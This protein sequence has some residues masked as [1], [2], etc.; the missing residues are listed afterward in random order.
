MTGEINIAKITEEVKAVA[1]E[2]G[3]YIQTQRKT[4]SEES[5]ERKSSHDYVSYVDK[6]S[7]KMITER[8]H[9]ILP[10]AGFVTEEHVVAQDASGHEFCWIVDPLDGTTNFIKDVPLYCVCIALRQNDEIIVGVV[11]ELTRNELFWAYKGGGAWVNKQRIHVSDNVLDNS[12]VAIGYPYNA[13]EYTQYVQRLT[14]KLYGNV[15]SIR[16]LGSAEGELCYVAAG[17]FD[18][19]VESFLKPWDVAAG[20]VIVKEAGGRISDY[21]DGDN[22]WPSGREVLAT[23]GA[24]HSLMID[25][26]QTIK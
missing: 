6:Q 7:E 4:F 21:S 20:A 2:A 19:Y 25:I 22:L 23:N 12:L 8:L 16:S 1:K 10:E 18:V 11:Y 15:A 5:V 26:I 13:K 17:R 9:Q 3:L 14:D 24:V